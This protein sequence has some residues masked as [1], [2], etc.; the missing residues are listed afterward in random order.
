M[1]SSRQGCTPSA[2]AALA[3]ALGAAAAGD[4]RAASPSSTVIA[5]IDLSRPFVTTAP[6]RFTASQEPPVDDPV[7]IGGQVP[8]VV[9]LCLRSSASGPC[10]DHLQQRISGRGAGDLY[11]A[12]HFLRR[13]AVVW[14]GGKS[15]PPLLWV[16]TGSSRSV[17]GGQLLF[18][19]VLAYHRAAGSFDRVYRFVTSSN[20]DQEVR[21][22]ATGAL[23]GDIISVEPTDDAP[24]AFWVTVSALTPDGPYRPVL[25]YRSATRYGDGNP[26]AVIDSEMANI[27]RRLHLWRPGQSLPLPP[28]ACPRPHLLHMALW[29]GDEER[30]RVG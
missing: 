9:D 22:V 2:I 6:W 7:G 17:D 1:T 25:R 13:A 15:R 3:L 19:Q 23:R 14:P 30:P 24:F 28:G 20:N 11:A 10:D 26:L 27:E 21:F 8:G 18:T 5:D 4:V 29:C 16:Q 12:P